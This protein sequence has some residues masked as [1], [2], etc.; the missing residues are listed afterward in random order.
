MAICISPIARRILSNPAA[1]EIENLAADHPAVKE[2]AVIGLPHPKW[3]ERPV[4]VVIPAEE[5]NPTKAEL[6]GFLEGKI[7]K[8]WMPDDVIFVAEIPH[9]ATGK[10]QKSELRKRFKDY[11]F[12]SLERTA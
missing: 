12:A 3:D 1:N 4:L 9:S 11:S 6:L 5:Q 8:W 10:I 7:A 2:A